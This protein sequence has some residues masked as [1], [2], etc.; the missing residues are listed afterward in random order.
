MKIRPS[1]A[2]LWMKLQNSFN[3]TKTLIFG[4]ENQQLFIQS[5]RAK[6][7]SALN[8]SSFPSFLYS[9]F[10]ASEALTRQTIFY[11]SFILRK[12]SSITNQ[13]ISR[14]K[15]LSYYRVRCPYSSLFL[16]K[17]FQEIIKRQTSLPTSKSFQNG[18]YT[19]QTI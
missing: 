4:K 5:K 2:S 16:G 6:P 1:T 14:G 12:L 9:S 3:E 18:I 17:D 11:E 8:F 10:M 15:R 13:R 7:I 19:E